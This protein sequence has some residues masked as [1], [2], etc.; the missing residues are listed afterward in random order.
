MVIHRI[1]EHVAHHNWF[2]VAV[3]LAIVV[4]GVF[5][6]TQ[7]NNWNQDRIDRVDEIGRAHV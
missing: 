1:R 4:V 5:L 3:D 6:G 7:A 2:A